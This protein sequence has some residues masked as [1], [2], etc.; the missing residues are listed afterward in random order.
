[1]LREV[2]PDESLNALQPLQDFL[3]MDNTSNERCGKEWGN[4]WL[5][6]GN[7]QDCVRSWSVNNS[8]QNSGRIQN[9]SVWQS[10]GIQKKFKSDFV[11]VVDHNYLGNSLNSFWYENTL[12]SWRFSTALKRSY[13]RTMFFAYTFCAFYFLLGV[14]NISR[15]YWPHSNCLV[16]CLISEILTFFSVH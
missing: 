10:A 4:A 6:F 8:F 11:L 7:D 9:N 16:G 2:S 13:S 1:M 14:T 12:L 15:I 5:V 3:R